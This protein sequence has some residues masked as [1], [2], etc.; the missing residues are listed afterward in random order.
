M[1]AIR[2]GLVGDYQPEVIAHQA[3]PKALAM[4]ADA[5][6]AVVEPI[7]LA[8]TSLSGMPE[9]EL[10]TY[11]AFWCVPASPY[12]SMEGALRAIRYAREQHVPFLGT[13]G[14]SQHALI[15]YARNVLGL[16]EADHAESNESTVMPLI[17]LLSCS[18]VETAGTVVFTPGS[19]VAA[20]YRAAETVEIYHC[21]YGLNPEYQ[22]LL[23]QG[24]LRITGRDAHGEVRVVEL[25]GHPFFMATLYQPERWALRGAVHP[26]ITAFV[27]AAVAARAAV[28]SA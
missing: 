6:G 28:P 12:Q 13:C 14:G 17:S 1:T 10:A 2:I 24:P 3:I 11:D 22:S 25:S 27:E 20:I 18:L 23:V 5:A 8:T 7:W 9:T 4:A 15:E 26:L 21:R 16:A 19:R